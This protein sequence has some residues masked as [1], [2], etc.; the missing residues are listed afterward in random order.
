MGSVC[1]VAMRLT[2]WLVVIVVM[3]FL[4]VT[5]DFHCGPGLSLADFT[6]NSI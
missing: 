1:V 5:E 2:K 4:R 6:G 3:S